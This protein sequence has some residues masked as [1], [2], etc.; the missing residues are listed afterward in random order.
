MMGGTGA[1]NGMIYARG[2]AEDFNNWA[3]SG[4]SGWSYDD[5]LPYF[6]KSEDNRDKEVKLT[7]FCQVL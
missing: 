6:I 2:N 5:V 7:K 3:K 4:N 1:M